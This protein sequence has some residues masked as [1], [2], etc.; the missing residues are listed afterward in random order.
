[1]NKHPEIK[2]TSNFNIQFT[3]LK[4]EFLKIQNDY[5]GKQLTHSTLQEI[6][7]RYDTL[8]RYFGLE[9]LQYQIKHDGNG[10]ISFTPIKKIDQYAIKGILSE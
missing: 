2:I 10:I 9:D 8:F 3:S 7:I 4:E 1:M 5:K 6:D